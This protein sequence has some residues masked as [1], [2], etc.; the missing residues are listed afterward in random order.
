[1]RMFVSYQMVATDGADVPPLNRNIEK[2]CWKIA[3]QK[4]RLQCEHDS[5]PIR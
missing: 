5:G 3:S 1:M 4:K 2:Y